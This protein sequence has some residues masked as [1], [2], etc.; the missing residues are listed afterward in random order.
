[1]YSAS[2][3]FLRVRRINIEIK[4][5]ICSSLSLKVCPSKVFSL[6]GSISGSPFSTSS[7]IPNFPSC[8][9]SVDCANQLSSHL[10]SHFSTQ[11]PKPFQSTEKAQ[12]NEIRTAYC[13]SP[14]SVFCSPF[15]SLELSATISQ[16]SNSTSSG[17][18]QITNPLLT[19]LPQSALQFLLHI[20]NLAW[21]TRTFPSA[22][23]QS[24]VIHILKRGKP[25]KSSSSYCTISLT[26]CTFKLF[27]RLVLGRLTNFVKKTASFHPKPGARTVLAT[28]DFAKAFDSSGILPSM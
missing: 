28:V 26:S 5:K 23:K 6:L 2:V 12:M 22:W 8:Y 17:P 7:D 14:H 9:T 18:D 1:M 11:T 16:L 10:Q 15:S 4:K 27:K 19:H 25:S 20:F 3:A 24:T 13:N 21:S